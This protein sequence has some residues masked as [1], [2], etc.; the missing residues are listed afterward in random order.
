MI[1][2]IKVDGKDYKLQKLAVRPALEIRERTG[3]MGI[4][5]YEEMLEHVVIEP[6][7]T[8]DD[9]EVVNHLDN[10]ILA[11]VEYQYQGK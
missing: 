6:K 11:I 5:F 8:I 1:K 2:E 10:L 4:E 9:F 7:L 3:G